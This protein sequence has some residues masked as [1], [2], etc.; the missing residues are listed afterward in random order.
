MKHNKKVRFILSALYVFSFLT[1]TGC[2]SSHEL[3]EVG[4][5]VGLALDQG[6]ESSFEKKLKEQDGLYPKRDI[7][8]LTYQF[9]NPLGT[10]S[11]SEGKGQQK[12]F[13][14]ISETGDSVH[15]MTREFSLRS[16]LPVFSPHLKVIVI[17]ENLARK[18]RLEQLLD[19]FLRNNEIRPSC[20]LLISKGQ[21]SDTL[22]SKD[23]KEIPTFR[24]IG[25]SDN[26]YRT[27]RISAPVS[28]AKL[29]GKLQS[30]SSFLVQNVISANGEVKFSGAAVI[31]AKSSKLRG[32]LN[33]EELEGLTWITGKGKGGLVKTYDK[34][35]DQQI[36]YEVKTMK[37][38]ITPHIKGNTI[39]FDVNIE[40]E[41]RISENWT[42]SEKASLK[43]AEKAVEEEVNRLVDHVLKLMQ[44][45]YKV[46]VAGFGNELRIHNPKMW[47]KVKKDWEQTFREASIKYNVQL[48]ITDYGSSEFS[49]LI[50]G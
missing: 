16:Q 14:N 7:L 22:E 2:W 11:N 6:K 17:S 48:T 10:G 25:I 43:T 28:L 33:E 5:S 39:S 8:T 40:S 9:V 32:F 37:S 23:A 34:E 21:A 19:Q 26:E 4:L 44:E 38:N 3:E 27:T 41:G 15:Q 31:E 12:A 36:I 24:L 47:E 45:D 46:D 18:Y 49:K 20:L 42:V 50:P 29:M 1:L 30:D 35:T 13:I